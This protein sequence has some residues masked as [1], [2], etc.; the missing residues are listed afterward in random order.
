MTHYVGGL[1]MRQRFAF[2]GV[3][4]AALLGLILL[5][6]VID[7][8]PVSAMEKMAE[9]V[10]KAKSFKYTLT[11]RITRDPPVPGIP[12][13]SDSSNVIYRLAS[14]SSRIEYTDNPDW[15]GPGPACVEIMPV[16]KRGIHIY[17]PHKT[18]RCFR[19]REA[20]TPWGAYDDLERLG[21]FSGEADRDLGVKEINGKRSSRLS[22]Q[23][24]EDRQ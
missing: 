3:G 7:T 18:F 5:S 9:N 11:V 23:P 15:K 8:R 10:R 1:S 13:V 2:G 20:D 17:H 21:T 16:G 6:G 19:A 22:G 14:G 12:T 4:V 24:E